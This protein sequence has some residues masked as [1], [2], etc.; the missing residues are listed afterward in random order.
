LTAPYRVWFGGLTFRL[1]PS[2][3]HTYP[4][5]LRLLLYLTYHRS[6]LLPPFPS[7]I[8]LSSFLLFLPTYPAVFQA[9]TV[10]DFSAVLS[11]LVYRLQV[12]CFGCDTISFLNSIFSGRRSPSK[13][14]SLPHRPFRCGRCRQ[15]R[16]AL[17]RPLEVRFGQ[18]CPEMGRICGQP[19]RSR[20]AQDEARR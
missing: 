11:F 20:G 1:L 17:A 3:T 5:I 15:R 2:L 4:L 14:A 9:L 8:A 19:E 6:I 18:A 12:P 7:L 13:H 16:P 10:S